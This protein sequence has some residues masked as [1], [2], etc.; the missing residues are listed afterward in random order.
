[1]LGNPL[2]ILS[3]LTFF[4]LNAQVENDIQFTGTFGGNIIDNQTY[5][6]PIGAEAWAGFSNEDLSIYP[7]NFSNVGE[8]TFTGSTNGADAEVYFKFEYNPYPET[9]PSFSTISVII[10]GVEETT[11]SLSIPAQGINTFSS[12]LLYLST[13]DIPVTLTNIILT[14]SEIVDP[15]ALVLCPDGDVCVNG[16]CVDYFG[17]SSS[18]PSPPQRDPQ[19]VI[20]FYSGT[21]DDISIDNFD[22]GLCPSSGSNE[23]ITDGNA[24]QHYYGPGCQGI[25]FNN[26]RVDASEFNN[27]HFDFYTNDIDLTGK[28]F[29]L[30]LLDWAGNID[31]ST[32][33]GLEV[34]FNG[35][36]NPSMSSGLWIS[37]DVNIS[38]FG[39]MVDGNLTRSDI[40]EIHITS[41][42]ENAW[43][44][45][46]YLYKEAFL[47]GTCSDGILNQNETDI[48]CGGIC[49][50]CYVGPPIYPAPTPPARA[51]ENVISI[52][53][54]AYTNI[55]IDDFDFGL[56][57]SSAVTEEFIADNGMQRYAGA[58]CQGISFENNRINAAEFTNLH[59]DFYTDETNLVGK[60]FNI[61]LVDWASNATEAGST[62]LEI[63]F[64]D[65]TNPNI[66]AS[67]WI[68]VDIDISSFGPMVGGSLTRSDIAEIHITS[69]LSNAWYDNLYLYKNGDFN[70]EE[71]INSGVNFNKRRLI[72]TINI[73]GQEV[74]KE[75]SDNNNQIL[76]YIFNDGSVE[77]E[78]RY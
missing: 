51:L 53:S 15:C 29:N 76:F 27:V 75:D 70:D 41:N 67:S 59:F 30:K 58:G 37:V 72:K 64:N 56:C 32:S 9:E 71:I 12:C 11:Y 60:V 65:G 57:E 26:N 40:A 1:M 17:P 66:T 74:K 69:N 42:L 47:L 24:I 2:M 49:E 43:Y 46:L 78:I 20:S 50:P 77:K 5:T 19:D 52:Y 22:F 8:I 39:S 31:E 54:D 10:S 73:L 55:I 7:L 21:Y 68:S 28:V 6:N 38:S 62:G 63:N 18:A 44:D 35:G 4:T 61:K 16:N 34:N 3:L 45:N 33:T 14:S 23:E 13:P 25:I 48:D 36:T